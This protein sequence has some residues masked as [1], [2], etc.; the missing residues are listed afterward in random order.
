[1]QWTIKA[2][3][4]LL[5]I[6]F[7]A[8]LGLIYVSYRSNLQITAGNSEG[9]ES[10]LRKDDKAQVV[11]MQFVDTQTI[12]GRVVSRIEAVRTVGFES[13]WY[14]LEKVKMTI[15]RANGLSYTLECP[16]AQFNRKTKEAE[17]LGGVHLT[18]SDGMEFHTAAMKFDGNQLVNK[19]PVRFRVDRWQGNAGGIL[20]NVKDDSLRLLEP[21]RATM[22]PAPGESA[23]TVAAKEAVFFRG[24]GETTFSGGVEV[25]RAYD[26]LRADTIGARFDMQQKWLTSLEGWGNVVIR[27]SKAGS[28]ASSLSGG[29]DGTVRSRRFYC[30]I[31]EGKV[32]AVVVSGEGVPMT[33][34]FSGPPRR[35]MIAK[36]IRI[37]I[38][39]Q[40]PTEIRADGEV[41]ITEREPEVRTILAEHATV[42]FDTLT[43]KPSSAL[44][45]GDFSYRDPRNQGT[46]EQATYDMVQR[47]LVLAELAG[48]QPKITSD[49]QSLTGNVLELSV[50]DGTLRA[51]GNVIGQ[52]NPKQKG[53]TASETTMFP[54]ASGPVFVNS[55]N[56]LFRQSDKSAFF[57]GNVKAWQQNNTVVSQELQVIG[58]GDS[59][60][61]RGGVRAVLYNEKGDTP[62]VPVIAK[63]NTMV[64]K[65]NDRRLELDGAVQ[66]DDGPR[67]ITASKSTFFFDRARKLERIEAVENIVVNERT[68]SRKGTGTKATYK[69]AEKTVQL[70]GDP[71]VLTD[72][73]GTVK[74]KKILIDIARNKVNV[75]GDGTK[76]EGTYTPQ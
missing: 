4:I 3:R 26:T 58:A 57:S 20:L 75:L 22:A 13:G 46:A 16:Q 44:L 37:A 33:A 6:A 67:Q 55:E 61:A 45:Y 49:G 64:A 70:D 14:T 51:R 34:F 68:T 17:V 32:N 35:D 71:A 36:A 73:R 15:Y 66:I 72:P 30:E 40:K 12:G 47:R 74:G 48:S 60:Y 63:A 25:V 31:G 56:G 29:E 11:A 43:A 53:A 28:G 24:R 19:V 23:M 18:S 38:T 59:L 8:F 7:V 50:A 39:D 1:M 42:Y 52:L 65:K 2:L 69:L 5:P 54:G 62:D 10:D 41:R 27:F 21:L 9:F 76:S